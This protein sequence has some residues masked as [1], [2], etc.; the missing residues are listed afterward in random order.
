MKR[1]I[2]IFKRIIRGYFPYYLT[3]LLHPKSELI[4]YY[5]YIMKHGD[6]H[7]LFLFGHEYENF[8]TIIEYDKVCGMPYVKLPNHKHKLYFR[9]DMSPRKIEGLYKSLIMEQDSRSP[10]RYFDNIEELR[11][12]ILLDIG[13][14]EGIIPLLAIEQIEHAYLFECDD[15][16]M[17]ALNK[18]F[19]PWKNKITIIKKYISDKNDESNITIDSFME[20]IPDG[21]F[22]IKMDIEG[23]ERVALSG[24]SKTFAEKENINFAVCTYHNNDDFSVI[25]TIL[26]SY[27]CKFINHTG[28]WRHK[29]RSV[30]L[31]G[32]N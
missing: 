4:K 30:M 19:E 2:K 3:K 23:M 11:G 12:K 5:K 28:Y 27:G 18:T 25:S 8:K 13:A 14:A 16:W 29:L 21:N 10:H 31:R 32:S 9:R 17:E 6:A 24:A 1:T 7:H 20:S 15:R 26:N 22:F